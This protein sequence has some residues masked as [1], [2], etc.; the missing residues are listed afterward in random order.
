MNR[1]IKYDP[2]VE[3]D[4]LQRQFFGDDW[5][6]NAFRNV[7]L[8][9]TDIYTT[10]SNELVVETHLPNFHEDDINISVDEGVLVI[11]AERHEQEKDKQKKYV[12]RESSSSFYRRIPLPERANSDKISAHLQGGML[13]VTV[14]LT[15]L[16]QPQ[17]ITITASKGASD[18]S[19]D[20]PRQ[21]KK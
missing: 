3:L 21:L 6:T 4:A 15:P 14:P 13:K 16:K 20:T 18:T 11:Q 19:G 9:T 10:D 1:L 17:K 8:A 7:A 2:F 12:V 5:P